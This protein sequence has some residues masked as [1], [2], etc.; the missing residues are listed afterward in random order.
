MQS[1]FAERQKHDAMR[2]ISALG[3]LFFYA[4]LMILFFALNDYTSLEK[5]FVGVILMYLVTIIIR[6]VYFKNRPDKFAYHNVIEKI[7]A[8]SFPSLHAARTGFLSV[9]FAY[10][11]D[12]MLISVIL[13]LLALGILFSR[14]Y[15]RKHDFMDVLAG[16]V[17]GVLA[18]FA[19]NLILA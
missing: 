12:N 2:D 3:S 8:A 1:E 4:L 17:L 13:P 16:A 7:D 15:L 18:Y 19:V 5:L 9:F 11:F 6:L 14:V 10:Y